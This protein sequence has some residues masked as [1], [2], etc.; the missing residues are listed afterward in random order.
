M[1][2]LL[3]KLRL[4]HHTHSAG[5]IDAVR[6]QICLDFA[7]FDDLVL[8]GANPFASFLPRKVPFLQGPELTI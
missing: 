1:T 2:N 7:L 6:S 5:V 3:V 8:A 4:S